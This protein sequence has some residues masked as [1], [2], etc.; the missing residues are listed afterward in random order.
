MASYKLVVECSAPTYYDYETNKE[1]YSICDEG[2][3][4]L[5]VC[6]WDDEENDA[7]EWIECFPVGAVDK[8]KEYIQKLEAEDAK[9]E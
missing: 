4:N 8:A 5:W 7:I 1:L 2:P 9:N 3:Q 6:L